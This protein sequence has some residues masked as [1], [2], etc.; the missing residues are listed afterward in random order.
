DRNPEQAMTLLEDAL[1]RRVLERQDPEVVELQALIAEVSREQSRFRPAT[2]V[3]PEPFPLSETSE[4]TVRKKRMFGPQVAALVGVVLA[5][6]IG[7]GGFL[8]YP[9]RQQPPHHPHPVNYEAIITDVRSFI[10]KFDW[11]DAE[12]ELSKLPPSVAE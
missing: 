5:L 1:Q 6:R 12:K 7:L 10:T 2:Q 11:D 8:K 4:A 9:T 3:R